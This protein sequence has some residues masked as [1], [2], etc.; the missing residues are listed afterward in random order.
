MHVVTTTEPIIYFTPRMAAITLTFT[1]DSTLYTAD[2][3]LF[4]ADMATLPDSYTYSIIDEQTKEAFV[5]TLSIDIT[6][7]YTSGELEITPIEGHFYTIE[8]FAGADVAYR[9]KIYCTNQ[10]PL[11]TFTTQ[12]GTYEALAGTNEYKTA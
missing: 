3:T 9:G 7:N 1:A 12:S 8:L 10:T 4:T 2:T 6:G 5:G 11:D